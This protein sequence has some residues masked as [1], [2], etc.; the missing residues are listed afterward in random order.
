MYLIIFNLFDMTYI[1]Y[2]S[3]LCI[4]IIKTTTMKAEIGKYHILHS[5]NMWEI[6]QY[7]SISEKG[8]SS[9]YIMD[10]VE[11]SDAIKNIYRLN[12]WGEPKNIT[13]RF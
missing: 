11:F 7:N 5:H 10:C 9:T 12:G 13:K 2:M 1:N 8:T 4:V 3:Y 6:F